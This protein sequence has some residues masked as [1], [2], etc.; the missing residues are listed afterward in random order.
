MKS[1]IPLT[2]TQVAE[3][4]LFLYGVDKNSDKFKKGIIQIKKNVSTKEL[5]QVVD[6]LA[7]LIQGNSA[8]PNYTRAFRRYNKFCSGMDSKQLV[9]YCYFLCETFG[10]K[11]TILF[12]MDKPKE[13]I[14]KSYQKL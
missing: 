9:D 1:K 10:V 14:Y 7:V 13:H 3:G 2:P 4:I 6:D 12:G 8:N 11:P 5:E